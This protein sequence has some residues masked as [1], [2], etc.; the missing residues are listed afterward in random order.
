MCLICID[1]AKKA[2]TPA[3]GRRNL[4]EMTEKLDK[5]HIREVEAKLTEAEEKS[6]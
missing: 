2:I 4:R 6:K 5:E 1:L 3:E